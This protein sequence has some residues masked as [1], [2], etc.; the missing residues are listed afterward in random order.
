MELA[1]FFIVARRNWSVLLAST[2]IG[3]LLAAGLSIALREP[4]IDPMYTKTATAILLTPAAAEALAAEERRSTQFSTTS[5]WL[6]DSV[7]R[8]RSEVATVA[9]IMQSELVESPV[10]QA[11][12]MTTD[13]LDESIRVV[14]IPESRILKVTTFGETAILANKFN[15]ELLQQLNTQVKSLVPQD[16]PELKLLNTS[17]EEP[18]ITISTSSAIQDLL[19]QDPSGIFSDSSSIPALVTGNSD[20]DSNSLTVIS[21]SGTPDPV[22]GTIQPAGTITFTATNSSEQETATLIQEVADYVSNE[23]SQLAL[24]DPLRNARLFVTSVSETTATESPGTTDRTLTNI[25]LG[26]II[27]LGIG[28]GFVYLKTSRDS[29]IRTPAQYFRLSDSPPL[30]VI[31]NSEEKSQARDNAFRVLRS[32]LLF[33]NPTSKVFALASAEPTNDTWRVAMA[34][35]KSISQIQRSVLVIEA[36]PNAPRCATEFN[37]LTSSGLSEVLRGQTTVPD[38]IHITP[39]GSVSVLPVGGNF[40][41]LSDYIS[42]PV[43][44]ELLQTARSQFDYIIVVVPHLVAN[45]LAPALAKQS[46]AVALVIRQNHTTT[47]DLITAATT[48]NQVHATVAGVIVTNVPTGSEN[49]W[50]RVPEGSTHST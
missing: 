16:T 38:A 14:A 6:V 20:F 8:Q 31:P 3:G 25:I 34:L 49:N 9:E 10:A 1:Y 17:T 23:L 18:Q 40:P 24:T 29:T 13:K 43:Y 32:N 39:H 22:T 4:A 46:D 44:S 11:L 45:P 15:T 2:I 41:E 35:A 37:L 42:A 50:N 48:L 19:A 5:T 33:A 47:T 7:F 28:G 21:N 12:G 26:A 30:A 36:D 27:G